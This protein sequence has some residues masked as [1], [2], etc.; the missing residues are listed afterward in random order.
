MKE[1]KLNWSG[2]GHTRLMGTSLELCTVVP[3]SL[4]YKDDHL[5]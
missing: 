1:M 4:G 2:L 3:I 5:A